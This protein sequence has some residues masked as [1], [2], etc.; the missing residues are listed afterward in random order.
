MKI[1]E[2]RL[3]SSLLEKVNRKD[4]QIKALF[5]LVKS[6]QTTIVE[7]QKQVKE[8]MNEKISK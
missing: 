7:L 8:L 4:K 2:R 5:K 6:Q 1:T 3:F